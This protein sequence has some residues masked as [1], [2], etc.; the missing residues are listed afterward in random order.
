[1]FQTKHPVPAVMSKVHNAIVLQDCQNF[2][3]NAENF[4]PYVDSLKWWKS[5]FL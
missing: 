1:M 2:H 5:I 4:V 3:E